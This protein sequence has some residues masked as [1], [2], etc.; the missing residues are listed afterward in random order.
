[1]RINKSLIIFITAIIPACCFAQNSPQVKAIKEFALHNMPRFYDSTVSA[2]NLRPNG[3]LNYLF[4]FYQLF[5]EENKFRELETPN[6]YNAEMS[7]A[8]SFLEDYQTAL[9]YHIKNYEAI[10]DAT[11]KQLQKTVDDLKGIV[12]ADAIKYISF[13]SKN[14]NVVMINESYNKPLHRA[15]TLSVLEE[16]YKKGFRYLAIETLNNFSK[17]SIGRF[18]SST[19]YLTNEPIGGEVIRI[20]REIGY[21]L[22]PYED[23][24]ASHTVNQRDS[25]RARNIYD[26]L[27]H[28]N[29]AK[30]L[31][32]ASY[33]HIAKKSADNNYVTMAMAFKKMSGIDPLSIDQVS[34]CDESEFAYGK[35]L[36]EA[37]TE[38][39]SITVPS[40]AML[41]NQAINITNNDAFDICV[42]H[43]HTTYK[44]N[45]PSWLALGGLRQ[46]V[47]VKATVKNSFLVQAYYEAE[48][49]LNGPGQLVPADQ[50]YIPTNKENYLLF[51]RAGRYLITFRDV[52]YH[53]IGKLSIEVN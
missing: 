47:Y 42:I 24:A 13:A 50:T 2:I 23:T 39:F 27:S 4:P 28:D 46:S 31:V 45:R 30:I 44:D 1:M 12:H 35:A 25:V 43:P 36:Y 52:G 40:V 8:A 10:D 41:G 17:R 11:Q 16:L 9:E 53:L 33:G 34:M 49:K 21:S 29:T 6:G 15:F 26:V 19:G 22:V 51:L 3:E 7:K 14:Y 37:Y 20:A 18:T 38:K 32:V 5:K 48:T